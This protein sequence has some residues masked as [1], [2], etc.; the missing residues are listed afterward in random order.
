MGE[1]GPTAIEAFWKEVAAQGTPLIERVEG[2]GDDVLVTFLCRGSDDTRNVIIRSLWMTW[3]PERDQMTRM[4]GTDVWYRTYRSPSDVR[5]TYL[6]AYN[7]SLVPWQEAPPHEMQA[8]F[9]NFRPD[10]LNPRTLVF[11][12]DG[13]REAGASFSIVELPNAAP[14]PWCER[15]DDVAAGSLELHHIRSDLL[16]N[17]RRVWI[18][19]PAGYSSVDDSPGLL[20]VFDGWAYTHIVPTPTILDN[21]LAAGR[22]PPMIAAFVDQPG[23]T[24]AE[25]ATG[26]MNELACNP[27]FAAFLADELVPWVRERYHVSPDPARTVVAGSSLGGLAAAFA[28]FSHP[29]VFGNVLSQSGSFWWGP[30]HGGAGGGDGEDE[31]WEWLTRR[32]EDS[33][34]L[35][36]RFYLEVGRLEMRG[37]RNSPTQVAANRRLRDVLLARGYP[38]RYH[39]YAGGHDYMWWRG[40][41]ADGLLALLGGHEAAVMTIEGGRPR[42]A[43]TTGPAAPGS[44]PGGC[45]VS[46]CP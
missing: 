40:T 26:R 31:A 29:D 23:E 38:L 15:G 45:S 46:A 36:L 24:A 16:G 12:R 11:P 13:L 14:Q 33:P 37:I 7:D 22:I 9:A 42:G 10:P 27:V 32:I 34:R 5:G 1:Q 4:P 8:R 20:V 19:T 21:L 44:A 28:G 35:A 2:E 39:E 41:I 17:E 30:G 25:R 3:V 18:Y 43:G 6:L